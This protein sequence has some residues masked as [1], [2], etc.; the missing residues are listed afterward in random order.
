MTV[1]PL[2]GRFKKAVSV[3]NLWSP[4]VPNLLGYSRESAFVITLLV[5]EYSPHSPDGLPCV[6]L[7]WQRHLNVTSRLVDL[8]VSLARIDNPL[9]VCVRFPANPRR[10]CLA[11]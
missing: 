1:L 8:Q 3:R 6:V 10:L 7:Q 9:I 11:V 5:G 4:F 2:L